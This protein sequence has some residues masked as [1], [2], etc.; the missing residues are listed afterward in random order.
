MFNYR[1]RIMTLYPQMRLTQHVLVLG[2]GRVRG[3]DDV[4]NGFTLDLRVI[5]LREQDPADFLIDPV[6]APLAVLTQG[7]RKRREKSFGAA[8][9]LIRDSGHPQLGELFQIAETLALIRLDSAT[10]DRI[11]KEN[12]MSI[13][14][15]VDHYR[16]TE[17]GHHLQRLGMERGRREEKE[18]MLLALLHSRFGDNP[19]AQKVVQRLAAWTESAAIDAILCAPDLETLLTAEPPS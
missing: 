18:T 14:P 15:L 8:L 2:N 7:P 4:R 19:G 6:L 10:I 9:R 1:A 11:R 16:N 12:G 17:V 13:Q 5:H 3:H